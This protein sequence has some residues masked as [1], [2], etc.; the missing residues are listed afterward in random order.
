MLSTE[1]RAEVEPG[2]ALKLYRRRAEVVPL[3]GSGKLT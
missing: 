3:Q 1:M 2:F